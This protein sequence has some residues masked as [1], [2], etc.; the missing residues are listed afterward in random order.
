MLG[1]AHCGTMREPQCFHSFVLKSLHYGNRADADPFFQTVKTGVVA[2]VFLC[3]FLL[4]TCVNGFLLCIDVG[5]CSLALTIAGGKLRL[6]WLVLRRCHVENDIKTEQVWKVESSS[7][8]MLCHVQTHVGLY[9]C[10]VLRTVGQCVT[11]NDF[12][13]LY[14]SLYVVVTVL[15][16]IHSFKS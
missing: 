8:H 3:M 6:S 10:C 4:C 7:S 15:M 12:T 11:R 2:C 9:K 14:S 16:L 13:V 5:R 1:V